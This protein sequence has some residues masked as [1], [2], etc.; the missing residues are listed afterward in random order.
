MV[1]KRLQQLKDIQQTL[2]GIFA[3]MQE[4]PSNLNN[5]FQLLA[6]LTN[7]ISIMI[8]E[9]IEYEERE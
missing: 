5:A 1:N 9:R 4:D 2:P 6:A 7:V 3:D 8:D